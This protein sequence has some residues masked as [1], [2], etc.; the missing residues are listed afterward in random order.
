MKHFEKNTFVAT[1]GNYRLKP[2]AVPTIFESDLHSH[3]QT[4]AIECSEVN[5]VQLLEMEVRELKREINVQ[6]GKIAES[7]TNFE[8][9]ISEMQNNMKIQ[10]ECIDELKQRV[11]KYE[12]Y[13]GCT[14]DFINDFEISAENISPEEKNKVRSVFFLFLCLSL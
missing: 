7:K 12:S 13:C 6:K 11:K 9:K 5:E 10:A 1:K 2:N 3:E 4:V 14:E 8:R